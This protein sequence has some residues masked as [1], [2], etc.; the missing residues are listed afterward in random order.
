MA[1]V[2]SILLEFVI[3]LFPTVKVSTEDQAG[4][5]YKSRKAAARLLPNYPRKE[6]QKVLISSACAEF[7]AGQILLWRQTRLT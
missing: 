3:I 4:L 6:L 7:V 5:G 2:L 1:S